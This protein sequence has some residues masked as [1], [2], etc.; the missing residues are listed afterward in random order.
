MCVCWWGGRG[1]SSLWVSVV[2]F[3]FFLEGLGIGGGHL[4]ISTGVWAS[5]ALYGPGTIR[6]GGSEGW[7]ES[8]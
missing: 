5:Y 7:E 2:N 6:R 4:S 8:G 3:F 1:V